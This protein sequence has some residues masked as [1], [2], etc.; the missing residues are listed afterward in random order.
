MR[1]IVFYEHDGKAASL[2]VMYLR[3]LGGPDAAQAIL[4][5]AFCGERIKADQLEFMDDVP[6][7]HR[8]KIEA[9]F[10]EQ[11]RM[12]AIKA[13]D[14][15]RRRGAPRPA[16]IQS[17]DEFRRSMSSRAPLDH[18]G[19]GKPGGS[20]PSSERGLADLQAE[21]ER[22]AGVKPDMRWG[23]GRLR[24]EIRKA[25]GVPTDVPAE[26]PGAADGADR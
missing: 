19:N 2:R 24:A 3:G 11:K 10:A 14:D 4:A 16:P 9:A 6:S 5:S 7:W 17:E 8:E 21:Y 26:A 12:D 13:E 18:D 1:T 20:K 23:E 22:F 25:A 15:A